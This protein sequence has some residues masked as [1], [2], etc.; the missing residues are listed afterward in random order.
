MN[1]DPG[2]P[3]QP[4]LGER[5]LF[6]DDVDVAEIRKLRQTLHHPQKRGAVIRPDVVGRGGGTY[7]VRSKPFWVKEAEL[8]RYVVVETQGE[9]GY[10]TLWESR[11]G[12]NWRPGKI[13]KKNNPILN[14]RLPNG[15]SFGPYVVLFD[16]TDPAPSR[17]YKSLHH[18][19]KHLVP[20][21]SSDLQNWEENEETPVRSSDEWNLSHDR[22]A[23]QYIATP[24]VGGVYGRSVG[25]STS[26][27]F[28]HWSQSELMFQTDELD[29]ELAPDMINWYMKAPTLYSQSDYPDHWDWHNVDVYNMGVFRYESTYIGIP[30]F[31]HRFGPAKEGEGPQFAFTT[32]PLVCSRDLHHW[33]RVAERQPFMLPSYRGSGAYDLAKSQPPSNAVVRD[34]ELWFYY[35]GLKYSGWSPKPDFQDPDRGAVCLAVLRRDGFLSLD[36]GTE[37]GILITRTLTVPAGTRRLRINVNAADGELCVALVDPEG[38]PCDP[39]R[40]VEVVPRPGRGTRQHS[41]PRFSDAIS[42]DQT[43]ALVTWKGKADLSGVAGRHLRVRFRLRKGRLFSYWFE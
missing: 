13:G 4:R 14:T 21:T 24:K 6:L 1:S 42:G 39:F 2:Q 15:Q 11:D 18:T 35:N 32:F 3:A 8:F 20:V 38:Q 10:S 25:L 16:E 36:A 34:Q 9:T 40:V 28:N 5:Q 27:D 22:S 23:G 26:S 29:Q 33:T 19:G 17:R 41:L 31:F 12:I 30:A 7:Q 37:P 43:A